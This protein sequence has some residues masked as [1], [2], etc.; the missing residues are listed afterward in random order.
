[1]KVA[2][3]VSRW[4]KVR[5]EGERRLE[6][7]KAERLCTACLQPLGPDEKPKRGLHRNTCYFRVRDLLLRGEVTEA[8]LLAAGEILPRATPGPKP[9]HPLTLKYG[10][11]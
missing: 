7:C 8:E 1:M 5:S 3:V 11:R 4:I 9:R 10:H 6:R 2:A